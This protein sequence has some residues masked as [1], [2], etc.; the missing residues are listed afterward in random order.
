MSTPLKENKINVKWHGNACNKSSEFEQTRTGEYG[1]TTSLSQK[2]IAWTDEI[3]RTFSNKYK[4][5][6]VATIFDGVMKSS[7][8]D[9]LLSRLMKM[10]SC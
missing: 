6:L 8:S 9:A 2:L 1:R 5:K 3:E 10:L 4:M 7:M